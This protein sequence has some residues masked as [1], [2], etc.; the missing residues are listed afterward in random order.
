MTSHST[1]KESTRRIDFSPYLFMNTFLP[2]FW[3]GYLGFAATYVFFTMFLT[4]A[5]DATVWATV[6]FYS[7]G[8]AFVV[9]TIACTVMGIVLERYDVRKAEMVLKVPMV[10]AACIIIL[11]FLIPS[12]A[13][14]QTVIASI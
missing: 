9:L 12:V 7:L 11:R 2:I 6:V 3:F 1:R 10:V 5:F 8:T 4:P 14:I 13:S